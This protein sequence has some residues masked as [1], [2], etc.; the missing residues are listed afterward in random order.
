LTL[1]ILE[2]TPNLVL[3]NSNELRLRLR[4]AAIMYGKVK[5][6]IAITGGVHT[7]SDVIK[8]NYGWSKCFYDDICIDKKRRWPY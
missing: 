1:R 8:I 6:N 5:P 4:W 2:I 7:G 3:S